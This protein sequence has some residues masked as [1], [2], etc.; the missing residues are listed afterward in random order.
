M[1]TISE[2]LGL[3]LRGEGAVPRGRRHGS[4]RVP[5]Q[6]RPRRQLATQPLLAQVEPKRALAACA[7]RCRG[8]E[9][10]GRLKAR[11]DTYRQAALDVDYNLER[12]LT[13]SDLVS[14]DNLFFAVTVLSREPSLG[15]PIRSRTACHPIAVLSVLLENNLPD[16]RTARPRPVA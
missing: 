9:M 3:D 4:R 13:T 15:S 12:I 14:S 16:R 10:L 2:P 11:D 6:K 5:A 8:G 7:L 1:V